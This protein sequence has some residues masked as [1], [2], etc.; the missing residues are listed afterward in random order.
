M[1]IRDSFQSGHLAEAV[2][3]RLSFLPDFEKY[4]G[5]KVHTKKFVTLRNLGDTCKYIVLE[6]KQ[7]KEVSGVSQEDLPKYKEMA[8]QYLEKAKIMRRALDNHKDII[9]EIDK[10]LELLREQ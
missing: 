5:D 3:L 9:G 8:I 7:K 2:N 4:Y 6:L 10:S 1:C